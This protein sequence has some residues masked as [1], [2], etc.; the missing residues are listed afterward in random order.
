MRSL[1]SSQGI[2]LTGVLSFCPG[3]IHGHFRR[4][5]LPKITSAAPAS[6]F[7]HRVHFDVSGP[8]VTRGYRGARYMAVFIDEFTRL[9]FTYLMKRKDHATILH[10][11]QQFFLDLERFTPEKVYIIR[12]DNAA[13]YLHEDVVNFL[14]S[15]N[16]HREYTAEY[17]PEQN[18]ICEGAI[19]Y[20]KNKVITFMNDAHLHKSHASLWSLSLL[21]ATSLSNN[22]PTL[23][24]GKMLIPASLV[25][26]FPALAM[27]KHHPFGSRSL[28]L[29]QG[30]RRLLD[31]RVHECLFLG[32]PPYKPHDCFFFLNLL[33]NRVISSRNYK[34]NDGVMLAP[35]SPYRFVGDL[36]S[37]SG[38]DDD[39]LLEELED[40]EA[41]C[42]ESEGE[43]A[44]SEESEGEHTDS[45][46]D[47]SEG[48]VVL[49]NANG[50]VKI[51]HA[52]GHVT[53]YTKGG[54]I[55]ITRAPQNVHFTTNDDVPDQESEGQR[56]MSILQQIFAASSSHPIP[57]HHAQV[58]K[59]PNKDK[60]LQ[61]MRDEYDS[62]VANST[63][64]LVKPPPNAN[65][66]DVKWVYDLKLNA[67]GAVVRH[68]AR[69]VCK[70][71]TQRH[72][73]DYF[74][75]FSPVVGIASLRAFL[76]IATRFNW[77]IRQV[78][79]K[80]AFLNAD[81]DEV[82]YCR[83]APLFGEKGKEHL[84]YRLLKSLYG[85]KQSSRCW[86]HCLNDFLVNSLGFTRDP[87][88]P[89]WYYLLTEDGHVIFISLYVDDMLITGDSLDF[90][91]EYIKRISERFEIKD[92]GFVHQILGMIVERNTEE[93][94]TK[95]HQ[96][97]YVRKIL[98]KFASELNHEPHSRVPASAD[99]YKEYAMSCFKPSS[100]T[101]KF[102]YRSAL[103][104][105]MYLSTCTRPDLANIVRFLSTF[106]NNFTDVHVMFVRRI[107]M[108]LIDT[109]DIGLL[110]KHSG[111]HGAASIL[112]GSSGKFDKHDFAESILKHVQELSGYSDASWADN[113]YD[114]TSN[115]GMCIFLNDHL[116]HWKSVKQRVAASSSMESEYIAMDLSCREITT[117][118]NQLVNFP[119]FIHFKIG[120]LSTS[121]SAAIELISKA[122]TLQCDNQSAIT[123]GNQDYHTK[124]SKHI[125]VD[126]HKVKECV[127]AGVVKL[128]YVPSADNLAD[129]FTKCLGPTIFLG[130]RK[131]LM[132]E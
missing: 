18:S 19:N 113:Y 23:I 90:I 105:I 102:D 76:S 24:R 108:Y 13:E 106:S 132:S 80:T 32:Y 100:R 27:G 36:L 123:V 17:T 107:F 40:L 99:T 58:F 111:V 98:E 126:F 117:F 73:V 122:T 4:R 131:L 6:R 50:R 29:V 110:Y 51:R 10:V 3:C 68:K 37:A 82:I 44:D 35:T 30:D 115:S 129:F 85:L 119:K 118:R 127:Q 8:F 47:L 112:T 38:G 2:L 48:D 116:I 21:Y 54:G 83:Q 52:T 69:L 77:K 31:S 70:G 45:D 42:E 84:V 121:D 55:S 79:V 103:G 53:E 46:L 64:E 49:E 66:I 109:T 128:Q 130:L 65:I 12:S 56:V 71:Y 96:A 72:G 114:G 125:N 95:I 41:E 25:P 97:P 75:T 60:W 92:L 7:L 9:K 5:N 62:L 101:L 93:G 104:C 120:S 16:V 78:D 28:V 57:K 20:L 89:C 11:M 22:S 34:I 26:S 63:W 74:E 91:D 14:V 43:K 39:D 61:A 1:A 87:I 88:E 94:Y 124:R 67:E 15:C 33:S 81:L 86:N 59:D